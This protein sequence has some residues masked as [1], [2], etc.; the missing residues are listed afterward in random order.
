MK[1][2]YAIMVSCT[3]NYVQYLNALLNSVDYTNHP[4]D[5]HI[6]AVT[7]N[8]KDED[9]AFNTYL[10]KLDTYKDLSFHPIVHKRAYSDYEHYGAYRKIA[11]N[12]RWPELVVTSKMGRYGKLEEMTEYA[13]IVMLDV[14]MMIVHNI[15]HFFKLVE[16]TKIIIG[17]NERYK[18]ALNNYCIEGQK[19]FPEM[20][21]DW[22][23]CNAPLFLDPKHNGKFLQTA[24]KYVGTI[25]NKKGE[26]VSD[27]ISMNVALWLAGVQDNIV[28]LPNYAWTGVHLGYTDITTYIQNRGGNFWKAWNG[29]KVYILHGRWDVD[30]CERG[31]R[32]NQEKRYDELE[33]NETVRKRW[34]NQME[35][36]FKQIKDQYTFYNEK[37]KIRL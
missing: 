7:G 34:M 37:W 25:Q 6:I 3:A 35:H 20:P 30:G 12:M 24:A 14:D 15:M 33:L 27:I 5:V 26:Y 13:A 1:H 29:E 11:Q 18:W 31:W 9:E 28:A 10:D 36:V 17:C 8:K 19:D 4:V 2:Q 22:M 32:R 23:I 16:N 21:M